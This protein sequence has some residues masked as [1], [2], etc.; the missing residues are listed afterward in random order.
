MWCDRALPRCWLTSW[1]RGRETG[2]ERN[3]KEKRGHWGA[4]RDVGRILRERGDSEMVGR[5]RGD[6][7]WGER[8]RKQRELLKEWAD[9]E[10][11]RV[12]SEGLPRD[13]RGRGIQKGCRDLREGAA[14]IFSKMSPKPHVCKRWLDQGDTVHRWIHPLSRSVAD[15]CVKRRGLIGG[16]PVRG[17]A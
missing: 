3:G 8:L 7:F 1:E 17:V 4:G 13:L 14:I 11:V 6:R 15:C 5:L 9:L 10:S 16:G 12:D 2:V